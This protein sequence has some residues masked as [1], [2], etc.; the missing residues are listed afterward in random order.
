MDLE[1]FQSLSTAE[2]ARLVRAAGP[3][4]CVFPTNGSRRWFMLQHLPQRKEGF[5]LAYLDTV[6]QRH[7]ELYGLLFDHGLDTLLTPLFGPDLLE[8]G[9]D[10]V[11]MAVEGLAR[12]AIH[13]D[14]ID[15]YREYGV[16]VRFYGD[17]RKFF[18]RAPYAHLPVLFD[19]ITA[20]TM[21]H[22][23]HRLFVGLFAHDATETI[24]ELAVRY[25]AEHRR[26]PDKRTLV[27]LYYGE[28]VA[29]VDLFIG[30][31][32]F[33]A[34][35]MPLVATG[36]ED[37]YFTV[38]PSL[39]LTTRQLRDILYDHLYARRGEEPDYSTMT[40]DDWIWMKSFY[41]ANQE[42]TLGVG[43]KQKRGGYWYPLPQ[44]EL[45]AGFA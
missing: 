5:A 37:L 33:C 45:P 40:S 42:K 25:H 9:G 14:F 22:S 31:D 15:F 8:R 41:R 36:N 32:K 30:F 13:P 18:G 35:D 24:A 16:R 4:V 23:R 27:E 17:Y 26:V 6:I 38:S 7:I 21:P 28:Y 29:P 34:F 19:Q 44:V 10:Y 1:T 43:A 11:Q 3:K 20:Q 39:Y 2:V 12:L